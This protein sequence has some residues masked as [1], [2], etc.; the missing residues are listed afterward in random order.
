LSLYSKFLPHF[1][2]THKKTA[3]KDVKSLGT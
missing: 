3:P 2:H 1:Y